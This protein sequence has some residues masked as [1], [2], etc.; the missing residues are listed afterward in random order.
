MADIKYSNVTARD[1]LARRFDDANKALALWQRN[2]PFAG[3]FT[4]GKILGEMYQDNKQRK[5]RNELLEAWKKKNGM[6]DEDVYDFLKTDTTP[7]DADYE[8]LNQALETYK[9]NGGRVIADRNG[10]HAPQTPAQANKSTENPTVGKMWTGLVN[11]S[12]YNYG[13]TPIA[14]P[15]GGTSLNKVI[16]T[17]QA[18][19]M[20]YTPAQMA[21]IAAQKYTPDELQRLGV[22]TPAATV[23]RTAPSAA[24]NVAQAPQVAGTID[25]TPTQMAEISGQQAALQAADNIMK[26]AAIDAAQ[27]S[28]NN[29][30]VADAVPTLPINTHG[31][32]ATGQGGGGQAWGPV[33]EYV[34]PAENM[35]V[36][37]NPYSGYGYGVNSEGNFDTAALAR[38]AEWLR[39]HNFGNNGEF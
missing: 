38:Y 4:A 14:N 9:N 24:A 10:Y 30:P 1:R 22:V 7:R 32:A 20:P 8:K 17:Q 34:D 23:P 18:S 39:D 6:T 29:A 35:A 21:Q 36:V 16:P 31:G 33:P 26:N 25:N 5:R 15:T 28:A 3:G 27:A 37:N 2:Q 11:G 12:S 13:G 19:P